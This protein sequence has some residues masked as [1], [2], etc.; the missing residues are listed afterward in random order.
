MVEHVEE[1]AER[2]IAGV[3][4]PFARVFGEVQRQ[5][6]VRAEQAEE[7]DL[8]PRRPSA[9]CRS[10]TTRA[11]PARTTVGILAEAHRLVHRAQRFA[12]ARLVAV[13]ALEPPQCL[14][15]VVAVRRRRQ[16]G[17]EGYSVGLAPHCGTH[18][19]IS[20]RLSDRSTVSVKELIDT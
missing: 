11:A 20:P 15:E 13:Q 5:R 7:P 2:R 9:R 16:R 14:I 3:A 6:T 18:R 10:R 8:Q 19:L 17:E 4:Q 1:A 12:P